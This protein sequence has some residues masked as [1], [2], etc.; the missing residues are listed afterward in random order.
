[1]VCQRKEVYSAVALFYEK[2]FF[3]NTT[4]YCEFQDPST[5]FLNLHLDYAP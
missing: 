5:V 1:M 4:V 3:Q 2:I